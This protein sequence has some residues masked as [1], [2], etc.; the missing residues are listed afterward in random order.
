MGERLR[1]A[2]RHSSVTLAFAALIGALLPAARDASAAPQ[3]TYFG[4]HVIASPKV[5][6]VWWGSYWTSGTGL[7]QRQALNQFMNTVVSAPG[8]YAF[9]SQY[10]DATS[11]FPQPGTFAGE[12]LISGEPGGTSKVITGAQM[13]TAVDGWV[14]AGLVPPPSPDLV[15]DIHLPLGV[16]YQ[17]DASNA[18]CT[19]F[20]A[21][22]DSFQTNRGTGGAARMTILPYPGCSGCTFGPTAVDSLTV[23][24][25]HELANVATD[26]DAGIAVDTNDLSWLGW[27]DNANG[28][29]AEI[30]AAA[31]PQLLLG[32]LTATQ[33]SNLDGACVLGGR[34]TTVGLRGSISQAA[35]G[36]PVD[37]VATVTSAVPN[38][39]PTGSVA[40][41]A[42]GADLGTPVPLVNGVA[43]SGPILALTLGFNSVSATFLP[44]SSVYVTSAKT[45]AYSVG[46]AGPLQAD[47]RFQG[48]E[49]SAIGVAAP[50][51]DVGP[52]INTFV[53]DAVNGVQRTVLSFPQKDGVALDPSTAIPAETY[54]VF[55]FFDLADVTGFRRIADFKS[56]NSDNGLYVLDGRLDFYPHPAAAP[57]TIPPNTYV[58]VAL[59]RDTQGVVT[60]YVDGVQ[61]FSFDDSSA[62]DGVISNDVLRFFRDNDAGGPTTEA[63]AGN[64]SRIE[65]F[66]RPLDPTEVAALGP[67]QAIQFSAPTSGAV[68]GTTTLTA[69][70]GGS[71]NLVIFSVDP[72]TPT[73]VC[74]VSGTDGS[75]LRYGAPGSCI[76]DANQAGDAQY[77]AAPTVQQ[78]VTVTGANQTVSFTTSAPNPA[79]EG[80][81][82]KPAAVSS[83]GLPVTIAIDAS[84]AGACKLMGHTVHFVRLGTCVVDATQGGDASHDPAAAQ[85]V[86]A[87]EA[88]QRIQLGRSSTKHPV[89]PSQIFVTA[90]ATSGLPVT[91]STTTPGV[92]I[93]D[94]MPGA[95]DLLAPGHCSVVGQQAGDAHWAP[96]PPK[97]RTFKVF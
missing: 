94:A 93:A 71:G 42:N 43:D 12:K 10:P 84:S 30:C 95:I 27:Y 63:S 73:G 97:T 19:E 78:T 75:T 77:D 25:S 58:R 4:G 8:F 14:A 31:P 50:L 86:I 46:I 37:F 96:A 80:G 92:C 23:L 76:V 89:A 35:V 68:G 41:R 88:K 67:A 74:D 3:L 21:A 48:D 28:Q 26:P 91:F 9:L 83:A 65:L 17:L 72:A 5:T 6:N 60:G 61:Q 54:T 40:F 33:W 39:V 82:Y 47:Y 18:S 29:I 79:A 66:N 44:A 11:Q 38:T 64:V 45:I 85:Q 49:Q 20:C 59:T 90:T 69:A 24:E 1:R 62:Q 51:A 53:T 16:T 87:V 13:R 36:D 7:L 57:A 32:Y 34:G 22:T 55:A 56:G 81:H 15:Y 70:G 2:R 52:G